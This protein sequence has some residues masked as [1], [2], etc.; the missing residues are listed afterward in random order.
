MKLHN[1]LVIGGGK[2]GTA[3]LSMLLDSS[4]LKVVAVVDKNPDAK[5]IQLAKQYQIPY[6]M[7]WRDY[8][9]ED[10]QIVVDVTG[11]PTLFQQ[12]INARTTDMVIIPGS[13]AYLLSNLIEEKE[14]L[15]L[16]LQE[17]SFK[18]D[19]IL[20]STEEGMIGVDEERHIILFNRQAEK[21]TGMRKEQALG[22][23]IDEV[24]P[25]FQ[26]SDTIMTKRVESNQEL[27]LPNQL[28][29]M[30][31]KIP[32]I[33]HNN[34]SMGALTVFK[35]HTEVLTLAEEV[36]NLKEIQ[37]MLQA[38]IHSSDDA[39]SVVDEKGRGLLINPAYTRL[40]GLEEAQVIGKPAT[41]DISEGESIHLKVL[42]T[43][44]SIRG[45]RLRVGPQEKE[46][47]VN[48]APIIVDGV[49][50]GSVGVIHDR[51]ELEELTNDL[52]RARR[53]I[54]TLEAKYTFEDVIGSSDDIKLAIAQGKIG[55]SMNH[56]ILL[57]GEAG[58]GKELFAHAIHHT[59]PRK[60]HKLS[61][62]NLA[63]Y[64]VEDIEWELMGELSGANLFKKE[65]IL[66]ETNG[67]TLFIDEI[68]LLPLD[69]QNKLVTF[70]KSKSFTPFQASTNFTSD[71]RIFAASS[72]NIEKLMAEGAFNEEL[73][74]LLGKL[75]IHLPS[76]R[77]RKEDIPMLSEHIIEKIN[78]QFG[79]NIFGV[80]SEALK[81]L[82]SYDWPGN[83][84]ELENV[85]SHAIIFMNHS[86]KYVSENHLFHGMENVQNKEPLTDEEKDLATLLE[87]YE[88]QILTS[89]LQDKQGNKTATAKALNISLRNLYYKI[90]K[91]GIEGDIE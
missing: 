51:Q 1:V 84:R 53:I 54:R 35:D 50:K 91:Y 25:V 48:V 33:D 27:V 42:E 39:I 9:N 46:V 56:S 4:S 65:S 77:E 66:L 30:C 44:R 5:A 41:V 40:T 16:Q 83:L 52:K 69:V 75:T 63:N 70:I 22:R 31:T 2:G 85:L 34:Q 24:F 28:K 47:L 38:I 86:E 57:R 45:K 90:E 68:H 59:S 82:Q 55:A 14:E 78:Q 72:A 8:F 26:L 89:K 11:D 62:M 15:I 23:D 49:L 20:N 32:I 37:T 58:T 3:I 17:G 61:T 6:S 19:L 12:L 60:H 87:E 76:L 71:V 18:Q 81:K 21:L 88:K 29:V 36:T 7:D 13:V 80:S 43:R 74:S 73:Y 79:R 67:G 64:N 10:V